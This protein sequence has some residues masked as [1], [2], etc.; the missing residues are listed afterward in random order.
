MHASRPATSAFR[1]DLW[2][3]GAAFLLSGFAGVT[4]QVAWQRILTLHSGIG[5]YSVAII[6][7]AFMAGLGAG[8]QWAGRLSQRLTA[9]RALRFFVRVELGI[10]A[11][12]AASCWL[13]YDWLYA[14]GAWLYTELW[15]AG[16]LHFAALAVPTVLMGMSLPLLAR[17]LV[18]DFHVAGRIVGLLYG[19]NIAGAGLGAFLAPWFLVRYVGIRDTVLLAAAANALAALL[20]FAATRWP[21][22]VAPVASDETAAPS[23]SDSLRSFRYWMLLYGVSGFCALSLEIIWFRILDVAIKSKGFTFGTLLAVYLLGSALGCLIAA[24]FVSRLRHPLRAFLL[25]QCALIGYAGAAVIA[26][27]FLPADLPGL[28]WLVRYWSTGFGLSLID[29]PLRDIMALHLGVSV[30][31]FG[32]ATV[33]MG[34]SFP[35]LQR[36]VHDDPAAVGRKVGLLQSMNIAGCVAGSLFVGLVSLRLL[37]STGSLRL[38]IAIGVVFA[39]V[40]VRAYGRRSI[41]A[42][43]ALLLIVVAIAIPSQQRLWSRLH[44]TAR[45][46]ALVAEDPTGVAAVIPAES[47]WGVFVEGKSHSWLP[48]GGIHTRLGAM[49]ALVHPEPL[50]VAIIGLGSGDTAWA[51]GCRPQTRSIHVF[52]VSAS[53]PKLLQRIAARE[54]ILDLQS[55][56]A[57]PRLTV[58]VA[59]GRNGVAA[60]DRRYDVIEADALWSDVAY[61]GDLYSVEFFTRCAQ[62]LK[63]GGILCTWAPTPRVYATFISV[64]PHVIGATNRSVLIGSND[65]LPFDPTTWRARLHSPEVVR[66]LGQPRIES[67][68]TLLNKMRPWRSHAPLAPGDVNLDLFPRDE[69][70]T[71]E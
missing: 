40:G 61:S 1:A 21:A 22:P 29:T 9:A 3:S 31:L 62:K 67:V 68:E 11:F 37:G 52:E 14:R 53:Q 69:F 15:R 10:A 54:S 58:E 28:S 24:A 36:A 41:F 17:A 57:D 16:L 13:Y 66:Y 7:A 60:R 18:A 32:P 43:A 64:M 45:T 47:G 4:Y 51:A 8:S 23:L 6:V 33:L 59:D 12:G 30:A 56:L 49:A 38:M 19:I 20:G 46:D 34:A 25:C 48:F 26:L 55:F 44:G 27:A 71:P 63:P 70:L 5:I 65:P 50:D 2:L 35:I 42:T 39:L